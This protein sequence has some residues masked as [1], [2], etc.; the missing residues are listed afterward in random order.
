MF[1]KIR[2]L[3][4]LSLVSVTAVNGSNC[5]LIVK[6]LSKCKRNFFPLK[7]SIEKGIKPLYNTSS[8]GD[9]F[10]IKLERETL[11]VKTK[12]YTSN[13]TVSAFL[14]PEISGKVS[15]PWELISDGRGIYT[16]IIADT[17]GDIEE[18]KKQIQ[19]QAMGMELEQIKVQS[20]EDSK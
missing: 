10:Q 12:K 2:I 15:K 9:E 4:L 18:E 7:R 16:L 20:S 3:M 5:L 19:T 17:L 8:E 13:E 14:Y 6:N 11:N 1:K